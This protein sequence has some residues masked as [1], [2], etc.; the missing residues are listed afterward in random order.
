MSFKFSKKEEPYNKC[1]LCEKKP[2]TG[3]AASGG[4]LAPEPP[5]ATWVGPESPRMG[6]HV[7]FGE[8][9]AQSGF[10]SYFFLCMLGIFDISPI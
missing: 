1:L 7:F 10:S 9:L 4:A 3:R 2:E 6:A 5:R 8:K